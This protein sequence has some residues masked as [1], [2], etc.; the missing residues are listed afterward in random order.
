MAKLGAADM[1]SWRSINAVPTDFCH[2]LKLLRQR[3]EVC[4]ARRQRRGF[5][6]KFC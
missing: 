5:D 6:V 2:A 1:N 3:A 4:V